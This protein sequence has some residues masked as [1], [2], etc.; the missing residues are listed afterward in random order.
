LAYVSLLSM[1]LIRGLFWLA[2]FVFFVFCFIVLF[3]YG[4]HDFPDGFKKEFAH[5]K[6]LVITDKSKKPNK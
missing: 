6:S 1:A 2:L 5:V 3:Q 4:V